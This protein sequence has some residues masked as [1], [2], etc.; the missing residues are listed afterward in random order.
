M[1]ERVK[2]APDAQKPNKQKNKGMSDPVH[3]ER[4]GSLTIRLGKGKGMKPSG[5]SHTPKRIKKAS[6][7][8]R[9]NKEGRK[10][11]PSKATEKG[12][13]KKQKQNA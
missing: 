6:A 11:K 4:R 3:I 10:S 5:V 13:G 1:N 9:K 12:A 7:G 2:S 8:K